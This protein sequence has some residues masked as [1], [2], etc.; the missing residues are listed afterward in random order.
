[1]DSTIVQTVKQAYIHLRRR[2]QRPY[3]A[4]L[5]AFHPV[6]NTL[7]LLIQCST[8]LD[9]IYSLIGYMHNEQSRAI[10]KATNKRRTNA[11]E[12]SILNGYTTSH[13]KYSSQEVAR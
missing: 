1:M 8:M 6:S 9:H 5:H 4:D 10:G 2:L 11:E 7:H 13:Q 12:T 3:R